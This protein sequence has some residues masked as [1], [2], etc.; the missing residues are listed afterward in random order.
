[1]NLPWKIAAA[2]MTAAAAVVATAAPIGRIY[3]EPQNILTAV[4]AFPVSAENV[5]LI[6]HSGGGELFE[7]A[8][9]IYIGE[10][11]ALPP[12]PGAA[13]LEIHAGL[14]DD[15]T[16]FF[17][18][19]ANLLPPQGYV[20]KL[21][22]SAPEKNVIAV[23]AEDRRGV[24]Y[25][26]C[27]LAQLL[28]VRDGAA[29]QNVAD[30]ADYPVWRERFV[31]DYFSSHSEAGYRA[32]VASK[33]S[34]VAAMLQNN[35][36]NPEWWEKNRPVFELVRRY[37]DMGA[38][39]FMALLHIYQQD[40]KLKQLN[41][42][43]EDEL[44]EL[45]ASC[46][47]LAEA[48]FSFIMI[49]ADDIT[50]VD[51]QQGFIPYHSEEQERFG[52]V[53]AAHGYMMKRLYD[54]LHPDFPDL[55]L[56]MVG[57]PYGL[58]HGIGRP[59]IDRYLIEWGKNA[60]TEVMWVWTGKGVFSPEV[61]S[62]EL[63]K[64][65]SLL[66]GQKVY[67]FDN[68][69]GFFSPLPRWETKFYPG[70]EIDNDGIVYLNGCF[71]RNNFRNS[72]AL[73]FLTTCDYLWNPAKYDPERS[74]NTALETLMG[75]DAVA[76]VN[77]L[78][79]IMIAYDCAEYTGDR[80]KLA[81]SP[82]E[83][84]S[85]LDEVGKLRDATGSR[86]NIGLERIA[87][88]VKRAENFAAYRRPSADI[89]RL[90]VPIV[91]DGVLSP[92]EW[93]SAAAIK[94]ENADG[95]ADAAA[96][97]VRLAYDDGGVWL[98]FDIPAAKPLPETAKMRDD[99]A[100]FAS[101]DAVELFLQFVPAAPDA[102]GAYLHFCFDSASNRYDER[103]CSGPL[104]WDGD[105]QLAVAET[106]TG[107]SAELFIRPAAAFASSR[108]IQ[109]EDSMFFIDDVLGKTPAP[110]ASGQVW[111]ANFHRVENH[112]GTV[113]SWGKGGFKF[114]LPGYFGELNLK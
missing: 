72:E 13:K 66:S 31:S 106:P 81:A 49:G 58:S 86:L 44:L 57:A 7:L 65:T 109:E 50:P 34:G 15:M 38:L 10:L 93:D 51:N 73:R 108:V 52:G 45:I 112:T 37:R 4:R 1:M 62:S 20:I 5:S 63:A 102:V 83:F 80:S 46:R 55:K 41:I 43:N 12:S 28:E 54:A 26:L 71:F 48:G 79:D 40:K 30:V 22:A 88:R 78:R 103:S 104:G 70:M 97:V 110:P 6:F 24:L 82:A 61:R 47:K 36:R 33:I 76:P 21:A 75:R 18:A 99:E 32:V 113:Q 100:V 64:V 85:A 2:L 84:Q 14:L 95:S 111:L 3:P 59:E 77:R 56:S 53:G 35:W 98:G 8:D 60:P 29:V 91:L 90:S 39:D 74:F 107:W 27:S 96:T 69:N 42:A 68:S 16:D 19:K 9:S 17:D 87:A 23:G 94:L 89:G 67:L 25:G 105:W 101:P 92:G 114:H 11:A